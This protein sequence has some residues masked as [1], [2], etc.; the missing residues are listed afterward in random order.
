MVRSMIQKKPRSQ[1]C[2]FLS[3]PK[4]RRLYER[5]N[6]EYYYTNRKDADCFDLQKRRL[7]MLQGMK[8]IIGWILK[9]IYIKTVDLQSKPDNMSLEEVK[10]KKSLEIG[11]RGTF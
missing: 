2:L 6:Q 3:L 11:L 4:L 1:R 9:H 5:H 10:P 7:W 8:K